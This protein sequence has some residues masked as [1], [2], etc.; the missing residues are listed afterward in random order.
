[1]VGPFL[2][3]RSALN[4]VATPGGS[5]G[6]WTQRMEIVLCLFALPLTGKFI[7]LVAETILHLR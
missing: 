2:E 5:L 1:M 7:Y 3:G 4:M 6:E